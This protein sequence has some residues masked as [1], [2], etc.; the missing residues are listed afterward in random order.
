MSFLLLISG[1]QL[2]TSTADQPPRRIGANQRDDQGALGFADASLA[3]GAW[4]IAKSIE[5][6]GVEAMDALAY[7]LRMAP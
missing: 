4:A 7:R 2:P 6:L 1:L 5:P 3:A